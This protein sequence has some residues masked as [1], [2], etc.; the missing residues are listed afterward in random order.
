MLVVLYNHHSIPYFH[1]FVMSKYQ[2]FAKE[3]VL[4]IILMSVPR[5]RFLIDE[6]NNLTSNRQI[7]CD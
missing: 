7:K 4:K 6:C 3:R 5:Y 1:V 2:R